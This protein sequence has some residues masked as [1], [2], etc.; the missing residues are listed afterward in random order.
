MHNRERSAALRQGN[1]VTRCSKPKASRRKPRFKMSHAR[2]AAKGERRLNG[3]IG[4][5]HIGGLGINPTNGCC[6]PK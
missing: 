5:A 4:N 6:M 3:K 1:C 2:F